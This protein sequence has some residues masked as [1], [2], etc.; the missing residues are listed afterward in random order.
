MRLAY[1]A[2][3]ALAG[4]NA[5]QPP[6]PTTPNDQSVFNELVE[7]GCLSPVG[8]SPAD[9]A[10]EHASPNPPWLACLYTIDGS[11]Q[12]CGVPCSKPSAR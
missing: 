5:C 1:L 7:A 9:V 10:A 11:V 4:C 6:V 12:S 8:A 2:S 3:L